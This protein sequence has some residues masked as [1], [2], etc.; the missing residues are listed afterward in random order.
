MSDELNA[1]ATDQTSMSDIAGSLATEDAS[2]T[3]SEQP[4]PKVDNVTDFTQQFAEKFGA[5]EAKPEQGQ[6]TVNKLVGEK[7]REALDAEIK[8][9]SESIND[10]VGADSEMAELYL[11]TQYRKDPNLQKIWDNRAANPEAL[12][13]ALAIVKQEWS[14]KNDTMVDSQV[15]ENQRALQESQRTGGS[16]QDKSEQDKFNAMSDGEFMKTMRG[17]ARSG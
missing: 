1:Q 13:K 4:A 2:T 14:A 7:N 16:V 17:I 8:A 6:E 5:L 15:R 10:G 3:T 9:A 12:A 11:E